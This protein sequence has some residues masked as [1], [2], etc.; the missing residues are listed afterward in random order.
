[1]YIGTLTLSL[2]LAVF[3]A[4]LLAVL[5]GKQLATPLLMLA[6]G[7]KQVAAGDLTP[8]LVLAGKNELVELTRSFSDMT[9]QLA[10]A[11]RI[12]DQ[13]RTRLQTILD[14]LTASVIVLDEI[15]RAH[16]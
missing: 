11:R 8:K 15:G 1:M 14:N 13:H 9:Q 7:M 2:F 5:L 4:V 16:V 12:A 10:G 6:K 3:G